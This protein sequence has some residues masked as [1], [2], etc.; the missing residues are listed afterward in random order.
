MRHGLES[1]LQGVFEE[2]ERARAAVTVECS[3]GR[4]LNTLF[5]EKWLALFD[6]CVKEGINVN[7]IRVLDESLQMM[8]GE[9]GLISKKFCPSSHCDGGFT[10]PKTWRTKGCVLREQKVYA[11]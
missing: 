6:D 5:Y 8:L 3:L 1:S 9:S 11:D 4:V 2:A 7:Q 10:L